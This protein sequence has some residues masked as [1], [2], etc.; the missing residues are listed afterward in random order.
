MVDHVSPDQCFLRTLPGLE[1]NRELVEE[2]VVTALSLVQLEEA[3]RYEATGAGQPVPGDSTVS[4]MAGKTESGDS[5]AP[6]GG[7]FS[8][9]SNPH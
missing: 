6:L 8:D 7:V 3:C 4:R 9:V 5:T 1:V 2:Q